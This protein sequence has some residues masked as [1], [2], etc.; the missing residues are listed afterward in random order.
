MFQAVVFIL[1]ETPF[2]ECQKAILCSE[3]LTAKYEIYESKSIANSRLPET[4]LS[5]VESIASSRGSDVRDLDC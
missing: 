4:K 5:Q 3:V 1:L 2:C